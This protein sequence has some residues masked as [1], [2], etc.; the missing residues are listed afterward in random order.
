M[1]RIRLTKFSEFSGVKQVYH[2]LKFEY[3][4]L[5]RCQVMGKVHV[6]FDNPSYIAKHKDG[7]T[8]GKGNRTFII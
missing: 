2:Q 1:K 6:I 8:R 5:N 3:V 7:H 4:F